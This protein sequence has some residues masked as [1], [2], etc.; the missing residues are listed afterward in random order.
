MKTKLITNDGKEFEHEGDTGF[1]VTATNDPGGLGMQVEFQFET[2]TALQGIAMMACLLQHLDEQ[3]GTAYIQEI[4]AHYA[5]GTGKNITEE[6]GHSVIRMSGKQEKS[7][8]H[9]IHD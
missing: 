5:Q 7:F 4:L 6:G 9:K 3:F 1:T 8:R 2:A